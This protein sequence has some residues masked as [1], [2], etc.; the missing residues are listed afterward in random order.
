VLGRGRL[1]VVVTTGDHAA[2]I[3]MAQACA[4]EAHAGAAVRAFFRDE[5]IPAICRAD[6]AARLVPGSDPTTLQDV[7]SALADLGSSG[8]V[9]LHACSSSL[10]IWGVES[11][12]LLPVMAGARGLIAF[13]AEDLAGASEVRTY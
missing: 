9:R 1:A 5:S 10:Y 4:D 2:L 6:V 12:D 11:K 8:D 7:A 3:T 13:L